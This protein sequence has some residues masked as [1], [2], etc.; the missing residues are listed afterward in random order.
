L[1]IAALGMA[2]AYLPIIVAGAF[3]AIL[4]VIWLFGETAGAA[5]SIGTKP[6]ETCETLVASG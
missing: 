1:S 4:I 3:G 5:T 2:V 6:S